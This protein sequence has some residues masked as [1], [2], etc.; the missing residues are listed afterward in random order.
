MI[1]AVSRGSRGKGGGATT[2]LVLV[3][4]AR[5]VLGVL[6]G[7]VALLATT[8]ARAQTAG[9]V[10][11]QA[12]LDA[13]V[14]RLTEVPDVSLTMPDA[15][16]SPGRQGRLGPTGGSTLVGLG[17][18]AALVFRDRYVLPMFG[19]EVSF[20]VGRRPTT[21][22]SVDGSVVAMNPWNT[23]RF[24]FLL[25]G[26]G[27]RWKH[28]RW[29]WGASLVSGVSMTVTEVK[30]GAGAET[31]GA[32]ASAVDLLIRGN[33]EVCRRL[34]PESRVC[35]VGGLNVHDGTFLNGGVM[36]LRME[37]GP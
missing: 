7:G 21:Y 6:L 15:S 20:S 37:M 14:T 1:R 8:S 2:G 17:G 29:M 9:G 18:G 24:S 4:D 3:S 5:I 28:R 34:D 33:V 22:A 12:H 27:L 11:G 25:P 36:A 19:M 16:P 30:V 35:I 31:L 32:K 26:A 23:Q 13:M 10:V